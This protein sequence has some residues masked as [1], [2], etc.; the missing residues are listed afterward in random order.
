M[1]SPMSDLFLGPFPDVAGYDQ[2]RSLDESDP[3]GLFRQQFVHTD[4]NLIYLDGNSLGRLPEAAIGTIEEVTR[5]QWGD[6]LIRAWNEG[7]WEM[8]LRLGDLLAPLVGAA[9]GEVIISDS[10]TVNLYKL[11]L[12]TVN[13]TPER[14]KIVTDDMNFPT[15]V[16]VLDGIAQTT[17]NTLEIVRSDGVY[18]PLDALESAI[19]ENTALVSLSHTTFKSGYTY[20][21]AAITEICHRVGARVLWD[22]SHSVGV[23]PIDLGAA[24]VDLAIG[25]TYKYLNG[26]PGSP[27]FLYVRTDLQDKLAN[28]IAGWWGHAD[29]FGF[30]LEF[31]PVSGIRRFHSGTMPILS[32]AAIE[33]GISQTLEAGIE[34]IRTKSTALSEFLIGQTDLHLSDLGFSIVTPREADQRGSHV[35]IANSEAWPI[36]QAVIELGKVIPDYRTP[37]NLRLGVSPLYTSFVD[38]HTAIQRI[39]SIVS[40][41]HHHHFA[42]TTT[43][44]T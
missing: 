15:D 43:V 10:T 13:S 20:D 9:P 24:N 41:G 1:R 11:A 38:V 40:D 37:D 19:D 6:R 5:N 33:G 28:P 29:P 26:G 31:Q 17:G 30:D 39:R 32:L 36:T 25:C 22:T 18:G 8:Q 27:A 35:S 12:A 34:R 2:A 44:V 21:I 16:Y 23:V 7:W 3:L 4:P 14:S 42:D